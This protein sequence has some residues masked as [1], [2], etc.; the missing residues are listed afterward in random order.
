MNRLLLQPPASWNPA[1]GTSLAGIINVT[2]TLNISKLWTMQAACLVDLI[3]LYTLIFEITILRTIF[4]HKGP[5]LVWQV[6]PVAALQMSFTYS[7][8][9]WPRISVGL[10]P[11]RPYFRL[12]PPPI[13]YF[14]GLVQ[15]LKICISQFLLPDE[16]VMSVLSDNAAWLFW[17]KLEK[18]VR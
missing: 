17:Q 10:P 4:Y 16:L 14:H 9:A 3:V 13:N 15:I 7:R 18:L 2:D 11:T 5:R 6:D 8:H 12:N 1:S